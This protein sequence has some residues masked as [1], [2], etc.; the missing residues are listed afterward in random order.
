MS[1]FQSKLSPSDGNIGRFGAA[2]YGYLDRIVVGCPDDVGN[3]GKSTQFTQP[4]LLTLYVF[5]D[6]L[7]YTTLQSIDPMDIH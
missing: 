7:L 6:E 5:Q 3:E 2:V 1:F 4:I